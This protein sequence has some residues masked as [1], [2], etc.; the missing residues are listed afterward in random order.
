MIIGDLA[1]SCHGSMLAFYMMSG[2]FASICN[3]S[4]FV[5]GG[6]ALQ[7][8]LALPP[9]AIVVGRKQTQLS[10][11]SSSTEAKGA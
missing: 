5:L 2:V 1:N 10:L 4:L 8:L 7:D 11:F 3:I 6:A 9:A